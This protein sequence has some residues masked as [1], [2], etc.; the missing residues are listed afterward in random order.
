MVRVRYVNNSLHSSVFSLK[1]VDFINN[2]LYTWLWQITESPCLQLNSM[3][4]SS[5]LTSSTK[6]LVF[7][8]E[9]P[10][11]SSIYIVPY[12]ISLVMN[13]GLHVH[14]LDLYL[15]ADNPFLSTWLYII[16]S[17]FLT[18]YNLHWPP[19]GLLSTKFPSAFETHIES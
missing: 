19:I 17:F 11:F 15:S 7:G 2:N 5:D 18:V 10:Y 4:F 14:D 1:L 16:C 9:K 13:P 6:T 8:T 12:T 3:V